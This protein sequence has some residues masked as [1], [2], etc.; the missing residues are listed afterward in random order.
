MD[1][2]VDEEDGL[3]IL[4]PEGP[5]LNWENSGELRTFS[6]DSI[7]TPIYAVII[8]LC[9]VEDIDS[10]GLGAFVTVRKN[11]P[12]SCD[13]LICGVDEKLESI[14]RLPRLDQIFPIHRDLDSAI[15][16]LSNE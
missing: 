9:D 10:D 13:V 12:E 6:P 15:D 7:D 1:I 2:L 4:R 8:D 14:F 5:R 16:S 11:A 3:A